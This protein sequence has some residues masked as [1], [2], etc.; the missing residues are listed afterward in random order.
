[1]NLPKIDQPTFDLTIPSTGK[2]VLFRPFLVKEE[3]LLLIAQESDSD[4]D[5]I[6]AMKQV[7]NNCVVDAD[8]D[9]NRI[10]TF[11]L[12]Y[13][14]LKIRARSVNNI[15]TVSY[16]DNE[17]E[18]IY[19]FEI[20]LDGLELEMPKDVEKV[21]KVGTNVGITM[22]Y[23]SASII[24]KI[25]EFE[26]EVDLMTFFIINCIDTIYSD[27]EVFDARDHSDEELAQFLDNLPVDAFDKIKDF[28]ET[29]PK[30]YH[31]LEY[32]N[33]NGNVRKIELKNI[34]DFFMWG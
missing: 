34:K 15:I 17:D 20:D 3:K 2:K 14:F 23:P 31:K 6:R 24:E 28:F 16:R 32:T 26:N 9:I 22:K 10:T 29:M 7:V 30:L 13:M 33:K 21:V 12:E 4:V 8:F 11:D 27:E 5:M 1:M 25:R 18:Q 19:E